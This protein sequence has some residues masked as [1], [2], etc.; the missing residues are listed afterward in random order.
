MG[1]RRRLHGTLSRRPRTLRLA[2]GRV[3]PA[4]RPSDPGADPDQVCLP[5]SA[6]V[7]T[8]SVK[9]RVLGSGFTSS[10]TVQVNGVERQMTFVNG[11]EV[12]VTLTAADLAT[13]GTLAITVENAPPGGGTSPAVDFSVTN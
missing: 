12:G 2:A 11:G 1:S 4:Q 13:P 7:G 10:S 3:G 9:V 6:S 8:Q 5:A